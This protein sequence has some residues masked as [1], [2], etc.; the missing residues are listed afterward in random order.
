VWTDLKWETR[1]WKPMNKSLV[2]AFV[3]SNYDT[4][5]VVSQYSYLA[6]LQKSDQFCRYNRL[7]DTFGKFSCSCLSG[8][9]SF[10]VR[11]S[12]LLRARR[13]VSCHKRRGD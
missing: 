11:S 8:D 3:P 2:E 1:A 13:V 5:E 9:S 6:L 12:L 4:Q 10:T 7:V